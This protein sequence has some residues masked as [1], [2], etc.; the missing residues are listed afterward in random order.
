MARETFFEVSSRFK[1]FSESLWLIRNTRFASV[2]LMP[3]RLQVLVHDGKKVAESN[4]LAESGTYEA[5]QINLATTD[6]GG[7]CFDIS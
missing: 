1:G 5:A 6:Y 7:S 4:L 3:T 2:F